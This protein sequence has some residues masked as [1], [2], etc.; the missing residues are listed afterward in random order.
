[1]FQRKPL[2]ASS[3]GQAFAFHGDG[4]SVMS[5][6][7]EN[8]LLSLLT[9]GGY[10]F[11]GKVRLQSYLYSQIAF[12][13]DRF[14]YLGSGREF[15]LGWL[16]A[17]LLF[18]GVV[19]AQTAIDWN[20][21]SWFQVLGIGFFYAALYLLTPLITV[22][23]WRFRLSRTAWRGVRFSFR[24]TVGGYARVFLPGFALA[25]V[26]LGAF[27]PDLHVRTRRYLV[28][29]SY[30][31]QARFTYDGR[32]RDLFLPMFVAVLFFVPTMGFSWAW[33]RAKRENYDWSRTQLGSL[34]FKAHLTGRSLGWLWSSN[35]VL[36]VA[37][38]GLAWP[39]T[40]IRSLRYRL[41][42]LEV[43]GDVNW[44]GFMQD[45]RA[46]SATGEEIGQVMGSSL[47]DGGFGL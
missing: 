41:T 14:T 10:Y 44:D 13:G 1:M 35:L 40:R 38:V 6:H 16:R 7:A 21:K 45:A 43:I 2:P 34:R 32:G 12:A 36:V 29:N 27:W 30:F 9:C 3:D 22:G 39:W 17:M 26:T 23:T 31:G 28:E 5:I 37:T 8:L 25:T 33:F 11:W 24:G 46:S 20:D 4:L 18:G 42:R 47:F 15:L 19:L